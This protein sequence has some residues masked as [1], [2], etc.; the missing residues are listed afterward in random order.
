[1]ADL[2][3]SAFAADILHMEYNLHMLDNAP[4]YSLHIDIMDGHFVPLCGF[5]QIWIPKIEKIISVKKDFHF[6]AFVTQSML[7][8][9]I[10]LRP[11]RIILH[12]EADTVENNIKML[13]EV[14][15]EGIE[16][17]IALAPNTSSQDLLPYL[18]LVD[19]VLI[20]STE[21]GRENSVFLESTY[22]KIVEIYKM[23]IKTYNFFSI[24]IDGGLS[25][26]K[27]QKCIKNGA[28]RIIMGRAFF[29]SPNPKE[30]IE[31]LQKHK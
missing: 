22:K 27:A 17:G 24:S 5:N 3:I 14:K 7:K 26:N 15:S 31:K 16:T 19:D 12:V 11:D 20:M 1:M 23:R 8:D 2:S 28:D 4:I 29:S 18:S 21:P 30:I 25:I 10:R 13:N 6:M 9:Y